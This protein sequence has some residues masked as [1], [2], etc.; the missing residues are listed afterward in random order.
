MIHNSNRRQ[1]DVLRRRTLLP[2]WLPA[3][4][5]SSNTP[6]LQPPTRWWQPAAD[7]NHHPGAVHR[8]GGRSVRHVPEGSGRR[9]RVPV[10]DLPARYADLPL[11][12]LLDGGTLYSSVVTAAPDWM[13]ILMLGPFTINSKQK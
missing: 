11:L 1:H 9:V 7:N 8:N 4:A 5:M 2:R 3:M 12:G 10:G 13:V 6:R